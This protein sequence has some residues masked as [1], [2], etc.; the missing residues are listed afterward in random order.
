MLPSP[1][2]RDV[3]CPFEAG[4]VRAVLSVVAVVLVS[5]GAGVGV[6]AATSAPLPSTGTIFGSLV[7]GNSARPTRGTVY[8]VAGDQFV[9]K[10]PGP[11]ACTELQ[12]V[13]GSSVGVVTTGCLPARFVVIGIGVR[14]TV[15]PSNGSYSLTVLPGAY[16]L[17]ASAQSGECGQET[18]QILAGEAVDASFAC[19]LAPGVGGT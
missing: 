4:D 17:F 16:H 7:V 13:D 10:I 11:D 1:I 8:V 2:S 3:P 6:L 19:G 9:I 14:R 18:V 12:Y 5:I 15:V